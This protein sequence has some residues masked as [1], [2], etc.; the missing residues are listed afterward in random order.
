MCSIS[1]GSCSYS[2]YCGGGWWSVESRACRPIPLAAGAHWDWESAG[3]RDRG[4]NASLLRSTF[5]WILQSHLAKEKREGRDSSSL[6][7]KRLTAVL[8]GFQRSLPTEDGWYDAL[9][10]REVEGKVQDVVVSLTPA[11]LRDES[12]HSRLEGQLLSSGGRRA[13]GR[14]SHS[15]S[16]ARERAAGGPLAL[17]SE[18]PQTAPRLGEPT[19]IHLWFVGA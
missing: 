9:G 12:P 1:G 6:Y 5:P 8:G 4:R 3:H 17:L 15:L 18:S 7:S 11:L 16:Q 14:G 19:C 10:S 2:R 13:Y